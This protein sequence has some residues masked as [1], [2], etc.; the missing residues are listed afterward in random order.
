MGSAAYF[1][2]GDQALLKNRNEIN[3]GRQDLNL[4]LL[5]L[6]RSESKTAI[7]TDSLML[8]GPTK[9]CSHGEFSMMLY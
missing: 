6:E 8:W 7:K 4:R 1:N 3:A 9:C 2:R 5:G